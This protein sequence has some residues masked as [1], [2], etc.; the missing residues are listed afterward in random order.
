VAG[1][2][3][4]KAAI[5]TGASRG[6]G[7]AIARRLAREGAACVLCARD[8]AALQAVAAEIRVNGSD[9]DIFAADLRPTFGLVALRPSEKHPQ[10]VQRRL[11]RRRCHPAPRSRSMVET[12][13]RTR[14][15]PDGRFRFTGLPPGDYFVA[16]LTEIDQR[17]LGDTSFL[18]QIS[19]SALRIT[20]T[21]GEKKTQDLRLA[22][23]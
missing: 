17:D 1:P 18:E 21:D 6:I 9:A 12:I 19:A 5:V 23:Q 2:F 11:G 20:L 7:R 10:T 3:V 8:E 14:S 4:G 22:G 15:S 13:S 16:A